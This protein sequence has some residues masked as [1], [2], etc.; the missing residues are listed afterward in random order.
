MWSI[1]VRNLVQNKFVIC[2]EYHIQPSEI[3]R[4]LMFEYEY[5]L[6]D[7]KKYNKQQEEQRKKDEENH[8]FRQPNM[9]QMMSQ[10]QS[11]MPKISIPKF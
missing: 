4:M 3:D 9:S 11:S 6:E 8:Q 7:I 10:A 1:D 5:L 2:R